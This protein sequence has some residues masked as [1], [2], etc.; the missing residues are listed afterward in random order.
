MFQTPKTATFPSHFQ[1]AFTTPQMPSYATPQ[2]QYHASMTPMQRPQT[3]SDTLRANFYANMQAHSPAN[4]VVTSAQPTYDQSAFSPWLANSPQVQQAAGHASFE[5]SQM[6]TPPPTRGTAAKKAQHAQ[7]IAFGTPSTIA[8][9]RFLTP[10]QPV[11]STNNVQQTPTQHP[12]LH[13]SPNVY[14]FGNFGPA[15]APV[16]PQTRLLWEQQASPNMYS[17]QSMLDDPF[18]PAGQ[19]P[20]PIPSTNMQHSNVQSV[21]FDTPAMDSFPVQPPHPRPSSAAPAANS[22]NY[23]AAPAIELVP[24]GVDPSLVYS[25][26]IRPVVRSSSRTS[27]SRPAP[28]QSHDQGF[29]TGTSFHTRT[30]AATSTEAFPEQAIIGLRRS[31]TTGNARTRSVHASMSATESL[32]RSNSITQVPRTA[33]PLK[34]VG[35]TPLGSISESFRTRPRASVVLTVD[36]NGRARTETK[37]MDDSPTR[38]IRDRYPGLFDSDSSDAESETSNEPPSRTASFTFPRGEERRSKAARLDAHL[39]NLE[40][41][42]IPRSSSSASN[43]VTPSRAAVAAAAQLRR[44]GSVRKATPTRGRR[45]LMTCSA[46]S[47]IDTCPMNMSAEPESVSGGAE[48]AIRQSFDSRTPS[49]DPNHRLSAASS[50][51]HDLGGSINMQHTLDA[52]NRRWSMMSFEQH[53]RPQSVS[54]NQQYTVSPTEHLSYAHAPQMPPA[55]DKSVQHGHRN[56]LIRCVCGSTTDHGQPMVQCVSCTQW[57]HTGCVGLNAYEVP[58]GFTCFLCTKPTK[59][60]QVRRVGRRS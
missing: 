13:F 56:P 36:E 51:S 46:S 20:S 7:Q 17:Q 33:S 30:D 31:N 4:S 6:Q 32:A 24:S 52:H 60:V 19:Q 9:R 35:K 26:P 23:S 47:L 14:Q 11:V 27:K 10:Q 59:G 34:R 5:S 43:R 50:Q 2:Q 57:L 42:S 29:D 37:R 39:E 22:I 49:F 1:D 55:L 54:P 44:Q 53:Q 58:A 15:S 41:L 18:A 28:A 40:G 25:S 38:S 48:E 8:S 16:M 21:T 12:Q 45:N 3:S